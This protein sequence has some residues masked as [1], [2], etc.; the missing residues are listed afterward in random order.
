MDFNPDDCCFKKIQIKYKDFNGIIEDFDYMGLI[1][2]YSKWPYGLG[3]LV[4]KW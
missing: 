4:G 3:R 2:K 1:K